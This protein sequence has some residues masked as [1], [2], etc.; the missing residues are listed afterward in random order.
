M[1]FFCSVLF[2]RNFQI[3]VYD[4]FWHIFINHSPGLSQYKCVKLKQ[5]IHNIRIIE[6]W[7]H[8]RFHVTNIFKG[9]KSIDY[10]GYKN[11]IE[12]SSD[13]T[14]TNNF[15]ITQNNC[16]HIHSCLKKKTIP[17]CF[18]IDGFCFYSRPQKCVP[19]ETGYICKTEPLCKKIEWKKAYCFR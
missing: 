6:M 9:R 11:R 2:L 1:L 10:P 4:L 3:N 18:L 14:Q 15:L 17:K 12:I 8:V 13:T 19:T 7:T 5:H 16:L